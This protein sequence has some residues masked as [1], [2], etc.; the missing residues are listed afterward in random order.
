MLEGKAA[1]AEYRYAQEIPEFVPGEGGSLGRAATA[2]NCY[3]CM[4]HQIFQCPGCDVT[5]SSYHSA[6]LQCNDTV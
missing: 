2:L 6:L 5:V 3:R 4:H 1:E